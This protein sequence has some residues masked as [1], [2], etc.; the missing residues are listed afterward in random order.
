MDHRGGVGSDVEEV[1]HHGVWQ[2]AKGRRCMYGLTVVNRRHLG[3][4]K[5]PQ[6]GGSNLK[7]LLIRCDGM[8][9][10]RNIMKMHKLEILGE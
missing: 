5:N 10:M 1:C 6:D 7:A 3:Y 4:R 9:V 2:S 8:T